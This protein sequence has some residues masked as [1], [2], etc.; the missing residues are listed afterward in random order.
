MRRQDSATDVR[1]ISP[2][3]V[4][5]G[6]HPSKNGIDLTVLGVCT[7]TSLGHLDCALVRFGQKTPS[8]PLHVKLQQ[9]DS[10]SVPAPVRNSIINYLRY[11]GRRKFKPAP[12]LDDL[13]GSLFS[14]GIKAF[15][16]K[17]NVEPSSIDLVGTRSEALKISNAQHNIDGAQEHTP[18]WNTIVAAETGISTVY[19]FTTIESGVARPHVHPVTYVDRIFLR[20]PSKFRVCLNIDEIASLSFIP[21]HGDDGARASMSH[22]VGPGSLLIDY[23]IRYCT[24]NDQS[25]DHD[26]KVGSLGTVDQGIV[27]RFLASH[28]YLLSPPSRSIATEMFGDHEAQQLIDDCL[29]NNLSDADTLATVTRATAQNIIKQYY[30]LLE[31]FFPS[32][33]K[34]DELF[35]CGPSARNLNI[36]DYLE[37]VLP[38]SVITKPLHDI[39]IPGD[40]HEAMCYAYL[41]LEAVL[42]QPMEVTEAPSASN[43]LHPNVDAIRAHFIPGRGW[44]ELIS[45]VVEFSGGQR[46]PVATDVRIAGSLEAA[47]QGM[48]IR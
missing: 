25:E 1:G 7:G 8:A 23:A 10:I 48:D 43:S 37:S 12:H 11:G 16:R 46:I 17:H 33:Q 15:C 3:K 44:D 24:S 9:F 41:A 29:Y 18:S 31:G 19:D 39:G 47:V 32:D 4:E 27:D 42:T 21:M 20:H 14:D 34:V 26:G 40:A 2:S 5:T 22:N 45:T 30:R 36:I 13:L 38:E 35:I 28:D 6:N